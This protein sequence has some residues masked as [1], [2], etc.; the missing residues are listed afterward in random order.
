MR[1]K[2]TLSLLSHITPRSEEIISEAKDEDNNQN[3]S[4]EMSDESKYQVNTRP[5]HTILS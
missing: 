4:V 2:P 3:E 5:T 1:Q